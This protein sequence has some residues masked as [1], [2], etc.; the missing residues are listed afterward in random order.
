MRAARGS[1]A[2]IEPG[3]CS[4]SLDEPPGLLSR[5]RAV[6][7][8]GT[9]ATCPLPRRSHV[10]K[11]ETVRRSTRATPKPLLPKLL[12]PSLLPGE[13]RSRDEAADDECEETAGEE[14]LAVTEVDESYL[15]LARSI[16]GTPPDAAAL[17]PSSPL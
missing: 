14:Q 4:L 10:S 11:S 9:T 3:L 8:G 5:R 15:T 6:T 12:P 13:G 7:R 2:S 1:P 17:P 16:R